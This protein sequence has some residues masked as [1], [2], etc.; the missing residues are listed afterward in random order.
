MSLR[1]LDDKK[2]WLTWLSRGGYLTVVGGSYPNG[3]FEAK[4]LVTDKWRQA[5]TESLERLE[6]NVKP[7]PES[8]GEQVDLLAADMAMNMLLSAK[9]FFI[10][11]EYL[12]LT[13]TVAR[14]LRLC[15]RQ[16]ELS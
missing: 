2:C 6:R 7:F 16:R 15:L 9:G 13:D 11:T 5:M 4:Y 12:A 1:E 3:I 8:E 14:I 10:E